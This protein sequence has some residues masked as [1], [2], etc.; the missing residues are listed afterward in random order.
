MSAYPED[1]V[2]E[3]ARQEDCA[4]LHAAQAEMLDALDGEGQAQGVVGRPMLGHVVPDAEGQ[5]AQAG[6]DFRNRCLQLQRPLRISYILFGTITNKS[7][8][9]RSPTDQG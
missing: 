4:G 3:E 1:V 8:S 7:R 5:A 6:H 2:E 9:S